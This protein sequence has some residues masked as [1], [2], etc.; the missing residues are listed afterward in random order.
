MNSSLKLSLWKQLTEDA[1]SAKR[2]LHCSWCVLNKCCDFNLVY[3]VEN[4]VRVAYHLGIWLI[5]HD[6]VSLPPIAVAIARRWRRRIPFFSE[7]APQ[8]R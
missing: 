7:I 3:I 1:V 5:P 4:G 6:N 2:T 8:V